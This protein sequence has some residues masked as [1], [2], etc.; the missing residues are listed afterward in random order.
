MLNPIKRFVDTATMAPQTIPTT[1]PLTPPTSVEYL[2]SLGSSYD[3]APPGAVDEDTQLDLHL[4]F[5]RRQSQTNDEF[6][7]V[8]ST[9]IFTPSVQRHADMINSASQSSTFPQYALLGG[10]VE[11]P[12]S[13][14]EVRKTDPRIFQNVS[15]PSSTF[16][17]GSQGSGKS[18][19][20][21]CI[22]ENCLTPSRLGK[23][24][25][26]LTGIVF[27][28]DTFI[29]DSGGMPC[30]AAYLAS[31]SNVCVRVLCSPTNFRTIKARNLATLSHFPSRCINTNV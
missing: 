20:L 25:R 21:S 22:L 7:E 23:L 19:T 8:A 18:H 16:I 4:A 2:S 6:H 24:P 5:I 12:D 17:C 1:D 11:E 27:H 29:S 31:D 14:S 28:Y 30:E 10:N 13:H 15:A 26:P 3:L 9:P